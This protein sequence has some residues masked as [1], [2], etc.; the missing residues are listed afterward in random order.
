[1]SVLRG[2]QDL[3]KASFKQRREM[4]LLLGPRQSGNSTKLGVSAH[5]LVLAPP[6]TQLQNPNHVG[7]SAPLTAKQEG[8]TIQPDLAM[9]FYNPLKLVFLD[10]Q[11]WVQSGRSKI[12]RPL[13]FPTQPWGCCS[14][15]CCMQSPIFKPKSPN[16]ICLWLRST[17]LRPLRSTGL[18]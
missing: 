1:M 6:R 11:E 12:Q 15:L 16:P 5:T 13:P 4:S 18:E 7:A 9:K 14:P 17:F 3:P 8:Q 2:L 10:Q